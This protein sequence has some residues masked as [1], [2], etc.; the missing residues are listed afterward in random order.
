VVL[1]A[2]VYT[3]TALLLALYGF[4]SLILGFITLWRRPQD[5]PR[6]PEPEAWPHVTVQL[7]LYNE[8][9]V[10]ERLIRA[11]AS[12]DYPQERLDIQVLDDSNDDTTALVRALVE[13]LH[14]EGVHI[15]HIRRPRREG[16]KAGALAYGTQRARGDYIAVFDADF[17]PPRDWL[18]RTVPYLHAFPHLGFVQTRWEHLNA[19]ASPITLAQSLALDGHFAVEQPARAGVGWPIAF[20]GS[21]GLWRRSAILDSGNWQAD[22]LCEDLDLSYRAYLR[23]WKGLILVD[24]AVPGEIPPLVSAFRQQQARWATGSIQTFRKHA[25]ALLHAHTLSPLARVQGMIHMTNYLVH[26]LM[27]L[28]F[29][30]TLPMMW[31]QRQLSLPLTYLSLATLGPPLVYF[32]GQRRLRRGASRLLGF[33]VITLLGLG[34]AWHSSRAVW[35]G[36]RGGRAAFRRTPKFRLEGRE[37]RWQGRRYSDSL[38]DL[39]WG[40]GMLAVYALGATVWAWFHGHIYVVP[41]LILYALSFGTVAGSILWQT[42]RRPPKPTLRRSPFT[43]E[44]T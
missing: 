42:Y 4:N 40:E 29:L 23:G 7:P 1:V 39:P 25:R 17:V 11:T 32:L 27:L 12:L 37:A 6:P 16:Y 31:A 20:N 15:E 38:R 8:V 22:T 35:R 43:I 41:F 30:L 14:L 19:L 33:P 26:P 24:T 21:A 10:A 2:W 36:L 34:L 5:P 18:K 13:R 3:A 9:N 28:V 44:V